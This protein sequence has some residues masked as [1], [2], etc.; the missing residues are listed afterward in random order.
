MPGQSSNKAPVSDFAFSGMKEESKSNISASPSPSVMKTEAKDDSLKEQ[1]NFGT[2]LSGDSKPEKQ[3]DSFE[4]FQM[5]FAQE[6]KSLN[7]DLKVEVKEE[8]KPELKQDASASSL[9][10]VVP[11][12]IPQSVDVYPVITMVED[13]LSVP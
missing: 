13:S 1:L 8:P 3:I 4:A 5:K 9:A 11:K 12:E 10:P 6:Q 7:D 2:L